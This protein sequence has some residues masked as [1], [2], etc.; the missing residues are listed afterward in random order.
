MAFASLLQEPF[1]CNRRQQ[2]GIRLNESGI[3]F[4]DLELFP[5]YWH[6]AT[7]E[8]RHATQ[9]TEMNLQAPQP[10]CKQS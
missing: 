7:T 3:S 6:L 5:I 10:K 8:A 9:K 4:L 2:T 1:I